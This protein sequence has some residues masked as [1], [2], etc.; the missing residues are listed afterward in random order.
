[1]KVIKLTAE[2]IK[3]LKAVEVTP[4]GNTVVI[5]GKNGAGKT[6]VLDAI[7][8]AL[9]GKNA[10]KDT[11][12]PIRE[13]QDEAKVVLDLGDL[14]VTRTWK[15]EKTAL[16]VESVDGARYPSPQKML[17]ELVGRLSFD[18][19]EFSQLPQREQREV[20]LSLVRLPFDP[21]DWEKRRKDLYEERTHV[22]REVASAR[23]RVDDT[24]VS[25]AP[26]TSEVSVSAL[27]QELREVEQ[28]NRERED[29]ER[30]VE[31]AENNVAALRTRLERVQAELAEAVTAHER[32]MFGLDEMAEPEDTDDLQAQLDRAEE[33][34]RQY[35]AAQD[36][37]KAQGDL[38]EHQA[39]YKQLTDALND[40]DREK[41]EAIEQADMPIEG[42]GFNED[43]VTYDGLPFKQCSAAE[44]LRISVAMAMAMN[45]NIRVIRITDGSLLDS[46]NMKL[47]E[48][49]ADTDDFQVWL[50]RV[51][52]SG[53]VGI[54]IEDGEVVS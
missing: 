54:V 34:N 32:A 22:G 52:D 53:D 3:R 12:H 42:L 33:D 25:V 27:M 19:L 38:D 10:T 36:H 15:G 4:D 8:F 30:V 40:M 45:P 6:S 31:H 46:D 35:R 41:A 21:V 2:N 7:W 5:S 43:G 48:Q 16:K 39:V 49:M 17:D 11:P 29:A 18:P 24:T 28:R 44:Q 26:P 51:S 37:L 13:G 50:E 1:M 9:G 23:A 20:L 14:I 47:I